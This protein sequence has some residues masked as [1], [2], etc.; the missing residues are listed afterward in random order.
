MKELATGEG[1]TSRVF[2][3]NMDIIV[4]PLLFV[5]AVIVVMKVGEILS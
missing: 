5:F 2:G 1:L 3:R 4:L